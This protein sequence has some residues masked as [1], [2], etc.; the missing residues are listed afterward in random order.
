MTANPVD[1]IT[2]LTTT[3]PVVKGDLS[4][5]AKARV[6][7]VMAD[8]TELRNTTLA[9]QAAISLKT[10]GQ[11][12]FLDTADTTTADDGLTCIIS[13][14]GKRFKLLNG[15]F[16][17]DADGTLAA[18][19]DTRV[20]S[21]KAV[22]TYALPLSYLDTSGT[23]SANS[24][25]KVPSQK[26]V[27]TYVDQ[28]VAATDAMVFKGVIDCS[29]N[30]N[31]PAA[32]RAWTYKVSVAGKIG[33]ASGINVEAGD[34]LLCMT[35]GTASGNQATVGAQWA[36]V[37]TNIDGAV[38]GPASSTSGNVPSFNGTGGKV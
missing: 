35:D 3:A 38:T 5:W 31:Y 23:L 11:N 36:I 29:A 26:A 9:G 25:T 7:Q 37:Q 18:N 15:A 24:D 27:K 12:Y 14:D 10:T 33:G 2:G 28:I 16:A 22:K 20:P 6:P 34:V 13:A 4:A 19:S 17:L 21:Q 30:P 1:L 8:A 32:D